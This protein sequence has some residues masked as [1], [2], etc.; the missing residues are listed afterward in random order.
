MQWVAGA[1]FL[2]L[3]EAD[4]LLD[5][6]NDQF[7]GMGSSLLRSD[8][9][10]RDY[11]LYGS[12]DSAIGEHSTLTLGL[13]G[14][15]RTA[16]YQDSA[17]VEDPFPDQT[18]TMEGGNLSWRYQAAPHQN[19]YVTLARG[20]KGGGFNIGNQIAADARRFAPEYLWSLEAGMNAS[21]GNVQGQADVFYMRRNSMQV[22]SSCQ[23]DPSNP[24]TFVFFTRNASHGEN[25]GLEAQALWQL[26]PRWQ[27]SG[28][29]G[30]LHTRYLGYD[31]QAIACPD[32][33]TL[34]LDGRAQS[35]APE[36]QLSAALSYEDPNGLFARI[37]AFATDGFYFAAGQNEVAQ[38]Y[39]LVNLRLGYQHA[40]WQLSLWTR[41]L[42]DQHY[43]VQGFF[44]GLVPPEFPN[45]R[46]VQ[47]GDPRTVGITLRYEL[48]TEGK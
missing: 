6:W 32:G 26:H 15:R 48:G 38:A 16:Q 11:A 41:N 27:L 43:A 3:K 25:Y 42:F 29:V 31:S 2:Q 24:S 28:S 22:Y 17:D 5:T 44:F 1:Y 21:L 9:R 7:V 23:L 10:S 4:S 33:S 46:F 36:Y 39:Q 40:G 35:F 30:L 45:Q 12:L 37:D 8:Y 18:N 14:E 34:A 19:L 20:F 13:R 47:N